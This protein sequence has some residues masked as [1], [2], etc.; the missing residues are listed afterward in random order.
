[1]LAYRID[2]GEH[3]RR[4]DAGLVAVTRLDWLHTLLGWPAGMPVSLDELPGSE[5]QII[6]EL[7]AGQPRHIQRQ[8]QDGLRVECTNTL[9]ARTR[10]AS[11]TWAA[12]RSGCM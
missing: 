1:M 8:A 3:V 12:P 5:Q 2:Q 6:R 10:A 7:P 4:R 9:P 11:L